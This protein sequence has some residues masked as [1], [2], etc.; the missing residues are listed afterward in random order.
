M[1]PPLV[2]RNK[3]VAHGI[4]AISFGVQIG[5]NSGFERARLSA[6]PQIS[7][8]LLGFSPWGKVSAAFENHPSEAKANFL[9]YHLL[10]H[11]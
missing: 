9:L 1:R 11:G 4:G 6:V 7:A 8:K 10:R 3:T 2:Y 5:R